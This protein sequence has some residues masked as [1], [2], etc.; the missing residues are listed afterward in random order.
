MKAYII[1]VIGAALL[2]SAAAA[3]APERWAKYI[4][5]V[6]GLIIVSVIMTPI[7][8]TEPSEIFAGMREES[9]N[10]EEGER[11]RGE[12]IEDELEKRVNADIE[13]RLR[14]EFN[15]ECRAQCEIKADKDGNIEGV[16]S[17]SISGAR[18]SEKARARLG[19]VYGISETEAIR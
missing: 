1:S 13:E 17:I 18:L 19:E 10:T 14:R 4:N 6:T 2:A 16:E 12:M 3:L 5:T 7:L 15:M 11:I 9:V 8:K